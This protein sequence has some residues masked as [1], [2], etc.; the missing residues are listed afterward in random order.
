MDCDSCAKM[1]ELD[2]ED[3]GIKC[4]CNYAKKILEVEL[5]DP[6]EHKK[7]KEIVEKGGYKITS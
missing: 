3:A 2:L 4:S 6:N 7:I 1:I 5:S